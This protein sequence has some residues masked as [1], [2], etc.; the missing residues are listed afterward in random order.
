M[1]TNTLFSPL[2]FYQEGLN[3]VN[4]NATTVTEED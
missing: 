4:S 3:V 1:T 2:Y